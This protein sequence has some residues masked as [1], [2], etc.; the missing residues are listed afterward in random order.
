MLIQGDSY[1]LQHRDNIATIAEPDTYSL[2]GG[3]LE[4]DESPEDGAVRELHEETGVRV[5]TSDLR[6]L[7]Q[8]ITTGKGPKSFG[9]PVQAYLYTVKI[10]AD[11][12]VCLNEGQAVIRLPRYAESYEN[13]NEFAKEAIEIYETAAR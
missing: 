5:S 9:K 3:T 4:N 12:T 13:L 7:H 8:Y 2:W 10:E 11:E 6:L 1:V